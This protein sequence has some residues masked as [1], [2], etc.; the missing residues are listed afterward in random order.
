MVWLL[1]RAR[2]NGDDTPECVSGHTYKIK[3]KIHTYTISAFNF[4]HHS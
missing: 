2:R 1:S 4:F 3:D